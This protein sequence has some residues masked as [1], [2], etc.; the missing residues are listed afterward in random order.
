MA[1]TAGQ[2]EG[3]DPTVGINDCV[4]FG[5]PATS[6]PTNGLCLGPPFPPAAQRWAFAV[7]L[8]MH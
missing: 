4:D 8:S 1:I 5:G 7:V 3:D 6:A 2:F